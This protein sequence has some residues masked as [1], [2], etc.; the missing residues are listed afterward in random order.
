MSFKPIEDLGSILA[1]YPSGSYMAIP[2]LAMYI[3]SGYNVCSY[4]QC[5]SYAADPLVC[6]LGR[7]AS[8]CFFITFNVFTYSLT[9]LTSL[10]SIIYLSCY[11]YNTYYLKI[12]FFQF[13]ICK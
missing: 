8:L 10:T 11:I 5:K 1:Q 9:S 12:V 4:K 3:S 6:L 2:V 7:I 13:Y